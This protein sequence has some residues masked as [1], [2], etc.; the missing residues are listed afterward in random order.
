MINRIS[1]TGG[2]LY[3]TGKS[4]NPK[5]INPDTCVSELNKCQQGI[6]DNDCCYIH[7]KAS[8]PTAK[9]ISFKILREFNAPVIDSIKIT[10]PGQDN[11]LLIKPK[12]IKVKDAA[13]AL[14]NAA[15]GNNDKPNN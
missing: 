6:E 4:K 14:L 7:V 10:K 15:I 3:T 2:T 1:F 11:K 13:R 8:S 9:I 5:F 12:T